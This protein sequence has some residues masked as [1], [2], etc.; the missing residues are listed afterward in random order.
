M[1]QPW[2]MKN[3]AIDR[4]RTTVM[5]IVNVTP[6]SF[7][8]GGRYF[9]PDQ[10][11]AHA[12][13]MQD[14]G[15]DIIDIGG[16]STRPGSKTLDAREEL[17]RIEPVIAAL[18]GRLR[19]PLSIDTFYPEVAERALQ[20]GAD[21]V[22]DVSGRADPTMAAV[23]AQTGAGWILTETLGNYREDIAGD[24]AE[25]L[26]RLASQAQDCGVKQESVCLD[27]GFGFEKD[28][29]QNVALMHGLDR[30]SALDYPLLAGV[31]RK[32]FIGA[33]TGVEQ[34]DERDPG[35]LAAHLLCLQ[36]GACIIRAHNVPMSLQMARVWDGYRGAF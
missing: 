3:A 12:L 13:S 29:A 33:L 1:K 7:S 23:V 32:R 36:K 11:V 28:A 24:V 4:E 30:V 10:A 22:N 27:P 18:R 8:D 9:D 15:A 6:D 35:T 20:L 2:M 16:Q 34:A 21:I 19:V 31:S 17:A 5:G 26:R 14:E 25:R